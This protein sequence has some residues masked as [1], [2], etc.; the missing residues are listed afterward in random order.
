[1]LDMD[2]DDSVGR[3]LQRYVRLVGKALGL[4]GE[5]SYVQADEIAHAYIALDGH[6]PRFPGHDVALV[7]DE[8]RGWSVAVE[9]HSGE[10]LLVV[11]HYGRDALPAPRVI[12]AWTRQVLEQ[13]RTEPAHEPVDMAGVRRRLAV[14]AA[15]ALVPITRSSEVE[16][17]ISS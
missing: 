1:M 7:W 6:H 16:A 10:D 14:Y 11:G 5:C 8:R 17:S 2:F 12:A 9:T 3:G 4:R 15:P 13:G